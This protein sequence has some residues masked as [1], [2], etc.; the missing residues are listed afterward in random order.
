VDEP[1]T[2]TTTPVQLGALTIETG[3]PPYASGSTKV[4]KYGAAVEAARNLESGRGYVRVPNEGGQETAK[5]I[6]GLRTAAIRIL[7]KEHGLKFRKADNGDALI[8]RS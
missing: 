1:K 5:L 7:G 3:E 6:G 2:Q 4:S 8:V